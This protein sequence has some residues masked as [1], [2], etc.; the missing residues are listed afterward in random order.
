MSK[1]Y[2]DINTDLRKAAKNDFQ[3]H[4]FRLIDNTVFENY[5]K[6]LKT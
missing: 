1:T 4:F 5:G 2:I 6:Y 3:K